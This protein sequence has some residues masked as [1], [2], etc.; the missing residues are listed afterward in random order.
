[1]IDIEAIVVVSLKHR[2]DRRAALEPLLKRAMDEGVLPRLD[3]E[4]VNRYPQHRTLIPKWWEN[5][6]SY[7]A[8]SREHEAVLLDLTHRRVNQALILEDDAQLLETFFSEADAFY[9]EVI[10]N[11][12]NWQGIFFGGRNRNGKDHVSARVWRDKGCLG[13]HAYLVNRTGIQSLFDELSKDELVVDWAYEL[14]M[15]AIP[16]FYSPK[17]YYVGTFGSWS[18]T[19][20]AFAPSN[21]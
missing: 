1:M 3:I 11:C 6:P 17:D 18:D 15:E 4:Y 21:S 8:A 16:E 12:P 9:H 19:L 7:Y 20:D 13:S 14:V 5:K 10:E 2:H